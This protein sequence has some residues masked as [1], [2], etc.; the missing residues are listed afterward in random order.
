M[1]NGVLVA[2]AMTGDGHEIEVE[3]DEATGRLTFD[4]IRRVVWTAPP[5]ELRALEQLWLFARGVVVSPYD[6]L[7]KHIDVEQGRSDVARAWLK[8][9]AV[10]RKPRSSGLHTITTR[11]P[12]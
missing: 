4:T 9:D 3:V 7:P 6:F 1:P 11:V 5:G 10:R 8:L 12:A 2:S